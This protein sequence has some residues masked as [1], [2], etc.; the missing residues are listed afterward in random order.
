MEGREPIYGLDIETDTS[1]DGLD[2]AVAPVV[3]VA[4]ST[5]EGDEVFTGPERSLLAAL[6]GALRELPAGVVATWNGAGFDLPF[7]ADRAG[8]HDLALGLRIALDP[9]IVSRRP[10]LAGHAG[11]YRGRWHDHRHID[12]YRLYRGD[13]GPALRVSCS[14][15][16]IARLVGLTP[17]E[18]DR[19]RIHTLPDAVLRA[20]VA[21]D[22]RLTR[23][24]AERRWP[25]AS[26]F[27]DHPAAV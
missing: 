27:A 9:T 1:V 25:A 23:L 26:R 10:P 12:A 5:P 7:L 20:Y 18:V 21:S 13:V 4:L 17:V 11:A 8:R 24:L 19:E 6:D 14:L 22:A 16:A 3:T 15:K 2:P